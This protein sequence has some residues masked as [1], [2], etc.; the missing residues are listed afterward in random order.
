MDSIG[1]LIANLIGIGFALAW[2]GTL[3]EVV[4]QLRRDATAAHVQGVGSLGHWNRKL[5][6]HPHR[7]TEL[8]RVHQAQSATDHLNP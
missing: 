3:C 4:T 7:Q 5:M 8:P 6:G 2:A 1:K